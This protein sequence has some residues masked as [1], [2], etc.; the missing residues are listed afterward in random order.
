MLSIA[1]EIGTNVNEE[2]ALM[3]TGDGG[4]IL[5]SGKIDGSYCSY[6]KMMASKHKDY[7]RH[8]EVDADVIVIDSFDRAKDSKSN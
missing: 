5:T 2:Q 6:V 3:S 8:I 1:S 7:D 4:K